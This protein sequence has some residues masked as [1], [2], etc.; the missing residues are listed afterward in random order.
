MLISGELTQ[1]SADKG[2]ATFVLGSDE[3]GDVL[4]VQDSS[5]R[6]LVFGEEQVV[7]YEYGVTYEQLF[8]I[9]SVCLGGVSPIDELD[10]VDDEP[11]Q[12]TWLDSP[13]PRPSN[14]CAQQPLPLKWKPSADELSDSKWTPNLVMWD[15]NPP[16]IATTNTV[17]GIITFA[18]IAA[19]A[20]AGV[21]APIAIAAGFVANAV[22]SFSIPDKR[23]WGTAWCGRGNEFTAYARKKRN[24][25]GKLKSIPCRGETPIN[26]F[27][28]E[29]ISFDDIYKLSATT[30]RQ[31]RDNFALFQH[32]LPSLPAELRNRD[33]WTNDIRNYSSWSK[34]ELPTTNTWDSN[35]NPTR[36]AQRLSRC[37]AVP[38]YIDPAFG[39]YTL[40]LQAVG[41]R[42]PGATTGGTPYGVQAP[43][44]NPTMNR[45]WPAT[46]NRPW[47][48]LG[49][50]TGSAVEG[51]CRQHDL[52]PIAYAGNPQATCIADARGMQ[53]SSVLSDVPWIH[54]GQLLFHHHGVAQP[55]RSIKLTCIGKRKWT[56]CQDWGL[57][58]RKSWRNK[59]HANN[60]EGLKFYGPIGRDDNGIASV[61]ATLRLPGEAVDGSFN[62]NI[63]NGVCNCEYNNE[64]WG[65]DGGDCCPETCRH[66]NSNK[67]CSNVDGLTGSRSGPAFNCLQPGCFRGD[68][69]N[70]GV[71]YNARTQEPGRGNNYDASRPDHGLLGRL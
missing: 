22:T 55:C 40:G 56:K 24:N 11:V 19:I 13:V 48:A 7:K 44:W 53:L 60:K 43:A 29:P 65:Y 71:V 1:L 54:F 9:P 34:H 39:V 32:L 69:R 26:E 18:L 45:L 21:A 52:A 36:L 17:N 41:V 31:G 63:G 5:G 66:P 33:T 64:W 50:K 46:V 59:Y 68:A 70:V 35:G 28:N 42:A 14:E 6:P 8:E 38:N 12:P 10:N 23:L 49:S 47:D 4:F 25:E 30:K 61:C 16:L 57:K 58:W 3:E 37:R 67:R 27:T 62:I 51:W 20:T 2:G 15:N